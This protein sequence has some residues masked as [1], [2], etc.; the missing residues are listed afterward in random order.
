MHD[1]TIVEETVEE[2]TV[3]LESPDVSPEDSSED[4]SQ[5]QP[6]ES[7]DQAPGEEEPSFDNPKANAAFAAMRKE[8]KSLKDENSSYK[9]MLEEMRLHKQLTGTL[10]GMSQTTQTRQDAKEAGINLDELDP[11]DLLTAGDVKKLMQEYQA[12]TQTYQQTVEDLQGQIADLK[13]TNTYGSDEW[14]R[15]KDLAREVVESNPSVQRMIANSNVDPVEGI[16][17]L[18]RMHN[19]YEAQQQEEA[20]R[21][22]VENIEKNLN[23]PRT[24]NTQSS[25]TAI[26]AWEKYKQARSSGKYSAEELQAMLD[27]VNR[28]V[29]Y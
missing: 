24:T 14:K 29:D 8:L 3:G 16:P 15:M 11:D 13:G 6:V 1:E 27:A 2:G 20:G 18:A 7:G 12:G 9:E 17:M 5:E 23:K 22:V 19:E 28:E 4:V 25:P 21:K 26:S 10:P